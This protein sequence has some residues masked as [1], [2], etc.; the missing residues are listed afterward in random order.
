MIISTH[1][2]LS[3][4]VMNSL[5]ANA[6]IYAE[7]ALP[8][9]MGSP[10]NVLIYVYQTD[11]KE[12]VRYTTNIHNDEET[13]CLAEEMLF[14]HADQKE[15]DQKTGE[16]LHFDMYHGGMGNTI[17]IN[18]NVTLDLHDHFFTYKTDGLTFQLFSSIYVI[19]SKVRNQMKNANTQS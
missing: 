17:F 5:D 3:K 11:T 13:Y 18:K 10:G 8:G 15:I 6:I 4:S 12:L 1:K 16:E 19:Y 7:I 14:Q 9:A 2:T